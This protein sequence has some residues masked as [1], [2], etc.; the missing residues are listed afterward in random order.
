[1]TRKDYI[2]AAEVVNGTWK[3]AA[4]YNN[5]TNMVALAVEVERAFTEFFENQPNFQRERFIDACRKP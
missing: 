3:R 5:D 2:R 4:E 1:M